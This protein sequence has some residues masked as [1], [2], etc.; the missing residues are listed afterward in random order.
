VDTT[1]GIVTNTGSITASG[2][3]GLGAFFGSSIT[4]NNTLGASVVSRLANGIIANGGGALINSGTIQSLSDGIT[5][6][7][8]ASVT[9]TGSIVSTSSAAI[10][11]HGNFDVDI[12]NAGN[13]SGVTAVTTDA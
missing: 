12:D 5:L 13:L 1:P 6:N 11:S 10:L 8:P 7:G 2:A 4:F 3:G 9:N